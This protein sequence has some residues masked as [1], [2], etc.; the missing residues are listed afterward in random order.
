MN[1][2]AGIKDALIVERMKRWLSRARYSS[3]C[4]KW[5][6]RKNF[7]SLVRKHGALAARHGFR[8]RDVF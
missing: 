5:R 8:E 4:P 6:A 1:A 3:T 2:G 7:W